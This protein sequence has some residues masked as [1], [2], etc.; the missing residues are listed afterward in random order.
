MRN[1]MNTC[2]VPDRNFTAYTPKT[3]Q[4]TTILNA[5]FHIGDRALKDAEKIALENRE[6]QSNHLGF[7]INVNPS[8]EE[9]SGEILAQAK[10]MNPLQVEQLKNFTGLS[11]EVYLIAT[12]VAKSLALN[13]FKEKGHPIFF[14]GAQPQEIKDEI[15]VKMMEMSNYAFA[16]LGLKQSAEQVSFSEEDIRAFGIE[17]NAISI[18]PA[19][20]SCLGFALLQA[21]E[22]KA[23]AIIFQDKG[24][25]EAMDRLLTSL[26]EW[27]YRPV[28]APD[29]GDLVVY[30]SKKNDRI[31]HVGYFTESGEVL[32]KLGRNN[33]YSHVHKLGD[34]PSLHG[35][36]AVFFR[37]EPS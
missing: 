17:K 23:T 11:P 8:I 21:R 28:A 29:T 33:P 2:Y 32:S 16:Q 31:S 26:D 35:D 20:M 24:E 37:K 19:K 15:L 14:Y 6:S 22:V 30:F 4:T 25:D 3:C 18:D 5:F 34:I 27:G 9:I 10:E 36:R 7:R 12:G 13:F 1:Q